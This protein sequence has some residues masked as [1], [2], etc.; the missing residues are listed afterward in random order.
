MAGYVAMY[1]VISKYQDF[2]I[3][4]MESSNESCAW[5]PRFSKSALHEEQLPEVR[6]SA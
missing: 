2:T 3:R 6:L 1:V 4:A 5:V